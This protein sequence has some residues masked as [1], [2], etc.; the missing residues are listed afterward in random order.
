MN[1]HE[2]RNAVMNSE[3]INDAAISFAYT[4][5]SLGEMLIGATDRGVCSLQFGDERLALL[6]QLQREF[7]HAA[8]HEMAEETQP[9]LK[10]WLRALEDYL[11][12]VQPHPNIPIDLRGSTFQQR[13]WTFLRHI[14][15]GEVRSY[16]Q[17]AQQM[18][19]PNATRAVASA[20]AR[21]RVAILVPC[22]RVIRSDGTLGGYRW[23]LA[24]KKTLLANEQMSHDRL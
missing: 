17:L 19:Q 15:V 6:S 5:T 16:Q 7:P 10:S 21:N 8:I 2:M 3:G 22:H 4:R 9:L 14:P 13:V 24:R 23:G 1:D 12:G 18:G 20:C 11:R